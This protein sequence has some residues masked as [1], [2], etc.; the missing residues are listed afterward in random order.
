MRNFRAVWIVGVLAGTMAGCLQA[1]EV[2]PVREAAPVRE[3]VPVRDQGGWQAPARAVLAQGSQ[4]FDIQYGGRDRSYI[5]H[6]PPQAASG[7]PLPLVINFHGGGGSAEGHEQYTHMDTVADQEGFLVVY[8]NGT[9]FFRNRLLTWNAG[10]CCGYAHKNNVDDVGFALAVLDQVAA[11]TPVDQSRVYAAGLSNGGMMAYRL[12]EQASDRIA[13][14]GSVAGPLVLQVLN[15]RRAVPLI[16]FHSVDDPFVPFNG[17]EGKPF[18]FSRERNFYPAIP[19]MLERL[20]QVLG[21][22]GGPVL[23]D[24]R[25]EQATSRLPAQWAERL[26]QGPCR[27]GSEIVLWRMHGVGHVWPGGTQDYHERML[28]ESTNVINASRQMWRFFQRYSLQG[29]VRDAA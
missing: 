2:V 19:Q 10:N 5:V 15:P 4:T 23:R 25:V 29:Q 27:D 20:G 17:G 24:K 12:A 9:G 14:V 28:G 13:A 7:R 8:P 6:V 21:C 16:H 22:R 11:R 3:V 18:P 26:E 1:Q